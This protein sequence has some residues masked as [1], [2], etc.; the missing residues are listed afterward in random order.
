MSLPAELS[1]APL[2]LALVRKYAVP[3]PR[4]TSY[5]PATRFHVDLAALDLEGAIA[6]DNGPGAGSL[7]LY[8]HL[9]FCAARC[10]YFGCNTIIT[11]D[12][13]M[14][15]TYLE[16][17]AREIELVAARI[18]PSRGVEQLHLGGGTPTFLEP[19]QL[20][21]L[22]AILRAN[23]R[24]VADAE[25]SVE[26]DPRT[27]SSAHVGALRAMGV[28][29]ASLGIQDTNTEVQRAI[30][31]V[32]PH[33]RNREAVRMFRDAGITALNFDLIYGL[34]VQTVETLDATLDDVL[35]LGPDRL[36]VLAMH[37]C[38]G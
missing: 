32:Q 12:R 31:R 23:F 17:L 10:W 14:S 8:V 6:A 37:T 9:P 25:I 11:R 22:N 15:A 33:A 1:V 34:P 4:Y 5:P 38:R 2:D 29:R 35:E 27:L 13:G 16:D 30:H 7:S 3:G 21:R 24:F 36:S 28:N 26:I 18:D 19:T 20:W